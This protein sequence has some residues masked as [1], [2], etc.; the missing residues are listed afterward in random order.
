MIIPRAIQPAPESMQVSGFYGPGAWAAWVITMFASWIPLFQDDNYTH[1]LH[2]IGYAM[3]TNWA[4]IDLIRHGIPASSQDQHHLSVQDR[5]WS[6]NFAASIA[7]IQLGVYQVVA[8]LL[9]C[10]NRLQYEYIAQAD[11]SL[12][13]RRR[14][15]LSVGAV[16]P[17]SM[18]L[19]VFTLSS[20]F[21]PSST[22]DLSWFALLVCCVL[23]VWLVGYNACQLL[24]PRK[25]MW[26]TMSRK[27]PLFC[28]AVVLGFSLSFFLAAYGFA[29][30]TGVL[31]MPYL[32][33]LPERC[34]LVPCAPQGIGEWDQAFSL[35][36][37]LFL[38]LYEFGYDILCIGREAVQGMWTIWQRIAK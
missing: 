22:S 26:E 31:Q 32:A 4:A 6:N 10:N 38:F 25:L 16:L 11:R 37:A 24:W 34:Y 30:P 3:Y 27:L 36:V 21:T 23:G 14:L 35:I 12:E 19:H 29:S 8:Q 1:N 13:A 28:A 9:V 2:F 7:V 17:L 33:S 18:G 20:A 15:I 5:A